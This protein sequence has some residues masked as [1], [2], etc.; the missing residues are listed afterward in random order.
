MRL[1]SLL[2]GALAIGVANVSTEDGPQQPREF[3][4]GTDACM[5][6]HRIRDKEIAQGVKTSPLSHALMPADREGAIEADFTGAPIK[7]EDVA[8]VLCSK[9]PEQNYIDKDL[10]LLPA[11]WDA[12]HKKWVERAPVD[13]A[14]S[15]I[16]CHTVGFDVEKRTWVSN[17]VGCESCHGPQGAHAK[18]AEKVKVA[19]KLGSLSPKQ[20]SMICGQC[21][22][23]GMGKQGTPWPVGYRPGMDLGE[24][25]E[26]AKDSELTGRNQ[27]FN[28]WAASPHADKV[29]CS[30]CHDPHN[31]TGN[32][33]L[34]RKPVNQLCGGCHTDQAKM[35]EHQPEAA[36]TD[37]CASCHMP[38]SSHRFELGSG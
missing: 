15:C 3:F 36:E 7:K 20:K 28:E 25:F 30:N 19:T 6:C 33:F 32:H 35:E 26:F 8:W 37:T 11:T 12:E 24:H 4:A 17:G 5:K 21:H 23:A 2:V 18:N 22:S 29:A 16:G 1:L 10:M 13:A 38:D 31:T 9:R 14:K 34:L 27:Y